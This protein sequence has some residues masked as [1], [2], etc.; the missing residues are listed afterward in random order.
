MVRACDLGATYRDVG[1]PVLRCSHQLTADDGTLVA[2]WRELL[3][4]QRAPY[5]NRLL[6]FEPRV[7][8]T[9]VPYQIMAEPP[10]C[11]RRWGDRPLL[12]G[13]PGRP[14]EPERARVPDAEQRSEEQPAR[15][16]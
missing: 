5:I 4:N 8:L 10:K 1:E 16:G 3:H 15:G 9:S 12:D 7:V 13:H 14:E 2:G 11:R 6:L